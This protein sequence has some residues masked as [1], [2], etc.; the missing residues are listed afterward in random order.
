[1]NLVINLIKSIKLWLHIKNFRF[2][3]KK[4]IIMKISILIY[5]KPQQIYKMN[6]NLKLEHNVFASYRM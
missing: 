6:N 2:S 3:D 5:K 1:M 4:D